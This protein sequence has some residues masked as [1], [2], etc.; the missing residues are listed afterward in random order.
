MF[1]PDRLAGLLL[2][3]AALFVPRGRALAAFRGLSGSRCWPVVA[4]AVAVGPASSHGSDGAV[5][6]NR[7]VALFGVACLLNAGLVAALVLLRLAA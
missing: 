5:V 7:T 4:L 6:L 1:L 3:G 2:A